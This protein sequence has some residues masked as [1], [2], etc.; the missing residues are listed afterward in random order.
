MSSVFV[1]VV[2]KNDMTI[3]NSELNLPYPPA[4]GKVHWIEKRVVGGTLSRFNE[5]P[6]MVLLEYKVGR[7]VQNGCGGTLINSRYVLTAVH[8]VNDP[9]LGIP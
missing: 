3:D 7:Q 9:D 1:V 4:C 5:F 2:G 8:C 6:W